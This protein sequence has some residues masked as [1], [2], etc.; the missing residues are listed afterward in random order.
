[1][2]EYVQCRFLRVWSGIPKLPLPVQLFRRLPKAPYLYAD[3]RVVT[4]MSD[5]QYEY[6]KYSELCGLEKLVRRDEG[7]AAV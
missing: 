7:Y 3:Q 1:M 5:S 4:L 2:A 6:S